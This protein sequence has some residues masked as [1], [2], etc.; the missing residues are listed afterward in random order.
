MTATE[1]PGATSVRAYSDVEYVFEP[2]S[3]EMPALRPYLSDLWER[4]NF[5]REM[6]RAEVRGKR[7]SA[8]VGQL[9]AVLD[10]MFQAAIYFFLITVL[11]G[12]NR[13]KAELCALIFC[14]FLFSLTT[15]ALNKGGRSIISGKNLMLNSTFP[16]AVL[17]L[18]SIYEGLVSLIPSMGVYVVIHLVCR[19]PIG[20][21]IATL[22]LLIA[23]QTVTN[24]G[25]AMLVATI[26]VFV[27]DMTN[28]L[29]YITRIFMF[30]TPVIFSTAT[31][32]PSLQRI[33]AFNPFYAL[34][35]CYRA[36]VAGQM[37]PGGSLLQ[38]LGWSIIIFAVGTRTFLSH[39]RAFAM[40]L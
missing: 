31:L 34:F 13:G 12:G 7:S 32:S 6:A 19:Q 4:R 27:R 2:H 36:V 22:P 17:P 9:W 37:P 21:G 14:V 40:R 39:E 8:V 15:T 20:A 26:T 1:A 30:T 33:L 38:A 29:T 24:I 16:R 28:A 35:V 10:P 23:I 11:R 18:A 25:F 3:A 5:I